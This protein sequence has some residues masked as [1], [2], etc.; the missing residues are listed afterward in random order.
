LDLMKENTLCIVCEAA[1][2]KDI[3]AEVALGMSLPLLTE[4]DASALYALIFALDEVYLKALDK[5]KNTG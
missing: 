2:K 1:N 5:R 4:P 3:A